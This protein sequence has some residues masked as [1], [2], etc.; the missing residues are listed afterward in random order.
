MSDISGVTE[1][2]Y[3]HCLNRS[4]YAW[5]W[6]LTYVVSYDLRFDID[7]RIVYNY[8]EWLFEVNWKGSKRLLKTLHD[9]M[10]KSQIEQ[11]NNKAWFVVKKFKKNKKINKI[12]LIISQYFCS[13]LETFCIVVLILTFAK[14]NCYTAP[15]TQPTGCTVKMTG[16]YLCIFGQFGFDKCQRTDKKPHRFYN[17]FPKQCP[18][19]ML[20]LSAFLKRSSDWLWL[21]L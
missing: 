10:K 3:L 7:I 13:W 1:R 6:Y 18:L 17:W 9:V 14:T 2:L 4:H 8:Q 12:P 15:V 5:W 20:S 19:T 21:W 11:I 16:S